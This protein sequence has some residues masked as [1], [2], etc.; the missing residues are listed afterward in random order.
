[1]EMTRGM[2]WASE[3]CYKA[4]RALVDAANADNNRSFLFR[5]C[6]E[7]AAIIEKA[8]LALSYYDYHGYNGVYN[9]GKGDE[10]AA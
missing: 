10:V 8:E 2:K 4:L 6:E 3:D 7:H 5:N 1:M 9:N